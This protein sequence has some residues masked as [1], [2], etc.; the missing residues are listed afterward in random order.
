MIPGDARTARIFSAIYIYGERA[1]ASIGF[2]HN[3]VPVVVGWAMTARGTGSQTLGVLLLASGVIVGPC[4]GHFYA[5]RPGRGLGT[6][7]LRAGLSVAG[8]FVGLGAS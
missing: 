4:V 5:G 2:S 8:L 6:A 1:G 3:V 7:A